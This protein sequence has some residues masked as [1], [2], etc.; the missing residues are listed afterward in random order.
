MIA[1]IDYGLG[2]IKAFANVYKQQNITAV[3]ARHPYQLREADKIILP[4]VGSFDYAMDLLNASG[5]RETLDELVVQKHIPVMGICVGMQI[6]ARSSEEGKS[7][8]LGW[9]DALVKRFDPLTF[10]HSASIPHMGWNDVKP[11]GK[12]PLMNNLELNARFYFLHSYYFHCNNSEDT[13]AATEYGIQF[14]SAVG[15]H[16]NIYG[17]QFHPEKSH[18]WG[19]QLLRNFAFL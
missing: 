17:V 19:V 3:I 13:I 14:A 16:G 10:N 5:M 4:G 2:N 1:I 8:G 6:L 11:V 9:I 7:P 18:Q 15:H 12:S